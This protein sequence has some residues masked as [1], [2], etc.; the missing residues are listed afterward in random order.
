M[1]MKM[2]SLKGKRET[3]GA[4][5]SH[6]SHLSQQIPQQ[7]SQEQMVGS[8]LSL[9]LHEQ[10]YDDQ[11]NHRESLFCKM[12]LWAMSDHLQSG[13]VAMRLVSSCPS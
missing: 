1:L 2:R 10:T 11:L 7:S 9:V 3:S 4:T 12:P 8:Y 13:Q 6:H 5:P